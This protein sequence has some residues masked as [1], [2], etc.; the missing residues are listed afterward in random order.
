MRLLAAI[1]ILTLVIGAWVA[2]PYVLLF[3]AILTGDVQ[4]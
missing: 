2:L 1:G 3:I 4:L